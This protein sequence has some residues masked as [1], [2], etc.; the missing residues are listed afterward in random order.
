M[1][2]EDGDGLTLMLLNP[3]GG[4][5]AG[6]VLETSVV[7]DAG[8]R[9]CLTTAAATRVY[10]SAGPRAEQT[11]RAELRAGAVLEYVPDHLIPS[12]GARLRQRTEISLGPDAVLLLS[13]AWAVGR[14]A[15]GEHWAFDELDLSTEL[16]DERGLVLKERCT[17]DRAARDG[18]GG[19]EGFGYVATFAA[20]APS[21][22][23]WDDLSRELRDA[24]AALDDGTR[25]AG[26]ALGRAGALVR[27]LCPSAPALQS[28]VQTVWNLCRRRLLGRSPL[29]L[30]KL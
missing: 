6:D 22:G 21:R 14:I 27:L 19:T 5:L 16:R 23:G 24:V 8:S 25:A 4:I 11:F 18:L 2:L 30:R 7:L 3:T 17:L 1:H 13:E 12:P 28:S 9:A 29:A 26:S 20:V 10:R 15:R